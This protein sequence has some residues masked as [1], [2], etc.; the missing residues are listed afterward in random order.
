LPVQTV[1][2]G[3][4]SPPGRAPPGRRRGL[5]GQGP[6]RGPDAAV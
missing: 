3:R 5:C 1:L 2:S 4:L 6:R